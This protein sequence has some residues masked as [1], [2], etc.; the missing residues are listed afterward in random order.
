[1]KTAYRNSSVAD[2]R[3]ESNKLVLLQLQWA[4]DIIKH[5]SRVAQFLYMTT[6]LKLSRNHENSEDRRRLTTIVKIACL[7]AMFAENLRIEIGECRLAM[8]T[9]I[10]ISS[11]KPTLIIS[12]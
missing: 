7:H 12:D 1:M 3:D 2:S 8:K 10:N 4:V 11:T 5:C 9:S 6:G